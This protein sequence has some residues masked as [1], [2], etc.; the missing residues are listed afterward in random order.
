MAEPSSVKKSSSAEGFSAA[1]RA[2]M[3]QRAA[4]LK[5]AK[6]G[7]DAEAQVLAVIAAMPEADRVIAE[8][9]H[10]VIKDVIPGVPTKTWYGFPAYLAGKDVVCFFQPAT[11]FGTR[12]AT[13]GFSDKARLDDG[14]LWPTSYALTTWNASVEATVRAL[15]TT[16]FS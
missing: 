15:V 2:A 13:L 12:Y 10:A 6:A 3:K 4:E 8:G 1:E 11:K 16:A 14:D 5:A 7:E 9:L